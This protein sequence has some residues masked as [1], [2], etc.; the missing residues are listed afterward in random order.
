[1]KPR[2]LACFCFLSVRF[3]LRSCLQSPS[4][5]K[6]A[7]L[8]RRHVEN[9]LVSSQ[10]RCCHC[11][12][13]YCV[14]Y[15]HT[16]GIRETGRWRCLTYPKLYSQ[17]C[18]NRSNILHYDLLT[19]WFIHSC[20]ENLMNMQRERE[21]ELCL[22]FFLS[23]QQLHPECDTGAGH[24]AGPKPRIAPSLHHAGHWCHEETGMYL[25]TVCIASLFIPTL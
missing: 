16:Y 10:R 18:I 23:G 12:R 4:V 19:R 8:P 9:E 7:S 13:F 14:K 3:N 21:R 25:L 11:R 1:M 2:V 20:N 17:N 5:A 6:T 15:I 24:P 22:M